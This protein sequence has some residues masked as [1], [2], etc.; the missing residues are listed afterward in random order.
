MSNVLIACWGGAGHI[1]PMLTAANQLAARGHRVRFISRSDARADV[2]AAG[3]G[4]VT[5]QRTPDFAPLSDAK[6]GMRFAY[7]H[8]MFGPAMAR[9]A[10]TRDEIDRVPT[11]VVLC[12][13]ALFGAF[14]GAE[15]ANV[16]YAI[17]SPTIS[18]RPLPGV[19][20]IMSQMRAPSTA[21]ERAQVEVANDRFVDTMSE[22]L[23]MLNDIRAHMGLA[24]VD[25]ILE[26]FD[27]AD[28]ALI[29]VSESFD[30]PA[31]Y[32]PL[33]TRYI[34]PLLD[35]AQWSEPWR[36][37][38][39]AESQRPRVLVS[40]ST[41]QQEQANALQRT[42]DAVAAAGMEGVATI[43]PALEGTPLDAPPG[44]TLVASA[45]H[46]Q[47]M[48]EVSL[49]VAHGGHGTVSR[50]L[51]HGLPL[52]VMPM[53]RDQNDIAA[54]VESHGAGL[55]LPPDA[56]QAEI[57]QALTR[58]VREPGFGVA[59]RRLGQAIVREAAAQHLV[60][61]VEAIA[62]KEIAQGGR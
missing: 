44:V 23:P 51:R 15:A 61:E 56:S 50:A 14:V 34:G 45:P 18:I 1:G 37:P 36:S 39:T 33:N 16:P 32:L 6:D 20:P 55:V 5:W 53:G 3:F 58:L 29:A 9:A 8:L 62:T 35:D 60:R 31:T 4:F 10:D 38:W 54:R 28:R 26:L 52:L 49:V 24:P 17:V 59:A 57:A 7:D 43:G 21:D 47:V 19:P 22:W 12:D 25:H 2:E 46:D 13:S 42:I 40:F 48:E 41:T 30:V 27:R 11:H